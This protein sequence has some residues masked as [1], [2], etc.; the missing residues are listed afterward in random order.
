MTAA[1]EIRWKRTVS[2]RS[3]LAAEEVGSVNETEA[4]LAIHLAYIASGPPTFDAAALN[5]C[6][7]AIQMLP[8]GISCAT[9]RQTLVRMRLSVVASLQ[10]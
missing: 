8:K 1:V 3:N 4:Y 2:E 5:A 10:K 7:N 9:F 6:S